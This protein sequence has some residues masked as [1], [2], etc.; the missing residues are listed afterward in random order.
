MTTLNIDETKEFKPQFNSDGLIPCVA[1]DYKTSEVLMVA[2]MNEESLKKSLET[3]EAHYWSRSRQELWH[4]GAT[5]GNTQK[6]VKMAID[7]DQDCILM[8]VEMPE[9]AGDIKACHTGRKSCFYRNLE[10]KNGVTTLEFA[11]E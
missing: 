4:K 2:Y 10:L 11:D 9:D 6:I 1:V 8:H 5:S 3:K 7:C